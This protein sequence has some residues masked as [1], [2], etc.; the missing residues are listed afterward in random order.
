ML[1]AAGATTVEAVAAGA[2]IGPSQIGAR[3]LE[4]SL[5]RRFH[6]IVSA[7]LSVALHPIGAGVVLDLHHLAL[8]RP[9]PSYSQRGA[10]FASS[11]P[12]VATVVTGCLLPAGPGRTAVLRAPRK[13][14]RPSVGVETKAY[15]PPPSWAPSRAGSCACDRCGASPDCFVTTEHAPGQEMA[16]PATKWSPKPPSSEVQPPAPKPIASSSQTLAA[17]V[18]FLHQD[19]FRKDA[20]ARRVAA[21]REAANSCLR[22]N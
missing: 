1:E 13:P 9:K 8:V 14:A 17:P 10:P 22:R 21:T 4:A 19:A 7:R 5:L 12:N 15:E 20:D 11:N 3:I 18:F 2:L 6:P 16:A